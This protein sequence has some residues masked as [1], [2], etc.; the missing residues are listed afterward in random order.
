VTAT[1]P[2]PTTAEVD[3]EVAPPPTDAA[4]SEAGSVDEPAEHRE[5]SSPCQAFANEDTSTPGW[6]KHDKHVFVLSTSGKPIYSRFGNEDKLA[7]VMGVMVALTSFVEED[8]DTLRTLVAGKHRYV[9]QVQ[10]PLV[11]V[12][13]AST[14]ESEA[15]MVLQLNYVFN[16]IIY[17]L[18]FAQ[19]QRIFQQQ[20]GFD[21]R[22]MLGGTEK[23]VDSLLDLF[24]TDPSF[25]LGAVRCLPLANTVRDKIGQVLLNSKTASLVFALLITDNQLVALLRPKKYSLHPADVCGA[26]F[27]T[28]FALEDAIG[29][30]A[31]S[32]EALACM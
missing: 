3:P 25:F 14:G 5:Y 19:L 20:P 13:V 32:L 4:S 17:V 12:M 2:D 15:H 1:T 22:R 11:F 29:S 31:C 7:S 30:H 23:F 6:S 18:T 27:P 24:D 28:V 26:R 10:G 9:F 16:Q 21:L 8:G